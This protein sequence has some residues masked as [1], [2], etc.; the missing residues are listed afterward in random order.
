[1]IGVLLITNA[2]N[3]M[4]NGRRPTTSKVEQLPERFQKIK[5]TKKRRNV[6]EVTTNLGPTKLST[7]R[8]VF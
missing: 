5:E 3:E 4:K 6:E 1:M 7:M 8:R 2:L